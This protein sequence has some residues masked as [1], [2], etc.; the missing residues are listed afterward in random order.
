MSNAQ[1]F[2]EILLIQTFRALPMPTNIA[3]LESYGSWHVL[4]HTNNRAH[5]HGAEN[6]VGCD[7]PHHACCASMATANALSSEE[8]LDMY[9][10]AWIIVS[11][12]KNISVRCSD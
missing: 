9:L 4:E 2:R 5:Q 7:D 1:V 12:L 6:L 8:R 11:L 10:L 3:C